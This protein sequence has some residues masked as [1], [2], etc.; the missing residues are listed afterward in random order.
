MRLDGWKSI[1]SHFG[2]ERS[3]VIRWAAERGMPVHRIPGSGRGSVYALTEE[4]DAWLE[5][6]RVGDQGEGPAPAAQQVEPAA[7]PAALAPK[8]WQ[9]RWIVAAVAAC[10]LF[11]SLYAYAIN[12]ERTSEAPADLPANAQVADLYL[13]A[14]SEWAGRSAQSIASA[15][16][17]L[18]QVVAQEPGFAPAHAALADSYILA[19]EFGNMEDVDAFARAQ[20]AADTALRIDPGNADALRAAGFIEYWWRN[21]AP[22][23][24]QRFRQAIA[25]APQSA[26]SHFWYGNVLVDNGDFAAGIAELERARLIEPASVPLQV[27]LAWARWSMGETERG[28]AELEALRESHPDL[29]TVRDC[30]SA[31]YMAEGNIEAFVEEIAALSQ[32]RDLPQ[33]IANAKQLGA[34]LANDRASVLPL[35]LAEQER[36]LNSG[37]STNHPWAVMVASAAGDRA[38]TLRLLEAAKARGERWGSAGM[39]RYIALRWP[40]DRRVQQLLG[41]LR[42]PSLVG[43]ERK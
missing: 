40:D 8:R 31:I 19:R 27:D 26:Q 12:R 5:D 16:A 22:A 6:N 37:A 35:Y 20:A 39:A 21:D 11:G 14:R 4:L 18:Q 41:D 42:S 30:L 7:R 17:K 15:I 34:A 10:F 13:S 9:G 43:K 36:K 23:A 29:A 32:L 2:R 1:G 33:D 3:T 28:K 25:A 24:A 38:G